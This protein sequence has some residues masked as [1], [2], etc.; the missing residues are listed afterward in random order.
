MAEQEPEESGNRLKGGSIIPGRMGGASEIRHP[1]HGARLLGVLLLAT[2]CLGVDIARA[3]GDGAA[4]LNERVTL[5]VG[6]FLVE[7]EAERTP[8]ARALQRPDEPPLNLD[9]LGLGDTDISPWAELRWRFARR[10]HLDLGYFRF[11]EEGRRRAALLLPTLGGVEPVAG[12]IGSTVGLDLYTASIGYSLVHTDRLALDLRLGAH[13][14]DL[15][16]R[17]DGQALGRDGVSLSRD[18]SSVL[19]PLPNVQVSV[20]YALT[21]SLVATLSGGWFGMSYEE[22]EGELTSASFHVEYRPTRHLGLGAGY[23]F[24]S[25]DLD[26][27]RDGGARGYRYEV[28]FEGPMLYLSTGF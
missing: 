4:I 3:E 28:D 17:V 8:R 26:V 5:R 18:D 16:W 15:L 10:W 22:Y 1:S 25:V 6:A 12:R 14:A 19:A 20:E 24:L 9:L 27:E 7:A 23:R 2:G 11:R 13:L 21:P